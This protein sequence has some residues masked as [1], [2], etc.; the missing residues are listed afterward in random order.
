MC[1]N[2][3]TMRERSTAYDATVFIQHNGGRLHTITSI[4]Y[5]ILFT[6]Q[7]YAINHEKFPYVVNSLCKIYCILISEHH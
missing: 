2:V 7:A 6:L 1:Y 3:V 5:L 4:K